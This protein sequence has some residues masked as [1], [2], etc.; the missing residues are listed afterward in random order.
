MKGIIEYK[1]DLTIQNDAIMQEDL[2]NTL[3]DQGFVVDET[4]R[5]ESFIIKN[6]KLIHNDITINEIEE[7]NNI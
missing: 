1:K 7:Y 3:L 6:D 5:D 4:A 2:N